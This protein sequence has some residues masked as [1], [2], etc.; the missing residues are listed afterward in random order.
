MLHS[1]EVDLGGGRTVTL[2]TGKM[3]KQ[4]N[5]SV[6]VRSGESV[7]LVTACSNP[8]PKPGANFFPLTVDY[9]E[10]T[11]SAG[12]FPGGFIKR[13]GR[14][15]E[16]ETL[17]CRL[18][19]RPIR[20]LFP[21]GYSNETQIIGL[22]LSA[23][24]LRDPSTL[25]IMGAGAALAISDIPFEHVMAGVR[26]GMVDGKLTAN[27]T[28]EETKASKIGIVVAGT[29]GGIVMVESGAQQATEAEVLAAI[30]FGHEC[31]K[32]ICKGI[33][34]LM[35][36]VGKTKRAFTPPAINQELYD[37]IAKGIT[38]E[39]KDALNTQKYEKLDSY[40][41]VDAAK[42]KAMEGIPEEQLPEAKKLFDML[43]ERIF[44]DEMLKERRR[45]DG[46]KFDEVRKIEVEV[47][48][49][50]RTHGSALF[51]R[52]ETQALVTA[53]LGTKDDEQRIELLDSSETSKRF[54]LHYN[55][56]PFSVGEVGFMRGAGRREIGHGAL[57]ERAV[58][59]VVPDDKAFP[60]TMRIVSDIME[61]NGSSSMASV[62]G[63][64]LALMDAGVPISSPV[65]GVAMGLVK[66]GD[67]YAILTDIAG[68]E[69]HYGDMDF[70]VAGTEAG[71]TA[72]QM[73]IK[74]PNVTHA[75]LKE[76]LEQA[77]HGRLHILGKM[78]AV[79]N[80]PRTTMSPYAPRIFTL[81][82]PTDKIRELIGPGGKVIR[83]IV[84]ATGCKIDVEDDGSVKIFSS[85]GTA[86][87]RC[88]QMVTDICA[89]AEVGKTYLGKVVRIVDFGA[90]VE[91]FPGTDGLLH[92]S[93]ISESRIKQVRDELNEGDQILV[94][95]LALEGN[96]IK[97][98]RKAILKE[99]REKLK[100][101]ETSKA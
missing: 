90:F 59:A 94:K 89:V 54:M 57:A 22:V 98:S 43:K 81:Q 96:K 77:R 45:P 47:G 23:D 18:I 78:N 2:E 16:K 6:I 74:V 40:A 73:D 8:E 46:R 91:I 12:R 61:S 71:I 60:Y 42:K 79:I 30:E 5:G 7:V 70:K 31:C 11:Y 29:E 87:D 44:R 69:D 58:A 24:P 66:E 84:E 3:A 15:S 52:G 83:G 72:L 33:H 93:E 50:P 25:A 17:T 41:R 34:E 4:A 53:T 76:A 64:T 100:Q 39:L 88:I 38:A 99:E 85:D 56:P 68:A 97:L 9:R 95:V 36:K 55:F 49:L 26:V 10:Y 37:Q 101:A 86:A 21:E 92:I 27:P 20:P 1:V 19:D 14:M 67:A 63:G 13:E 75:I 28:Y 82:I 35:K 32:K 48:V 80:T 62:C 65:A 51:T